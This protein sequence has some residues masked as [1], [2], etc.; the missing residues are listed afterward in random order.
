[1]ELIVSQYSI[2]S[3]LFAMIFLISFQSSPKKSVK[4][5]VTIIDLICIAAC[6]FF[7]YFS[8][9][10]MWA[11]A[12]FLNI[13]SETKK[14]NSF[15]AQISR[16]C[17]FLWI[18]FNMTHRKLSSY[19]SHV[20]CLHVTAIKIIALLWNLREYYL[21]ESVDKCLFFFH[22]TPQKFNEKNGWALL[23]AFS[24]AFSK[25]FPKA[26]HKAF[27]K[28]FL[29]VC[30]KIFLVELPEAFPETYP[31]VFLEWF[32]EAFPK[33]FLETF[34]HFLFLHSTFMLLKITI[35]A[36][37]EF[38]LTSTKSINQCRLC[39]S[40]SAILRNL[41]R[42]LRVILNLKCQYLPQSP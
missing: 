2:F 10:S 21:R 32:S 13:F 25:A 23:E 30:L 42:F 6:L 35:V 24:M 16:I 11:I 27:P 38:F 41:L 36:D 5:G 17:Y 12:M 37:H 1:M 29:K 4:S 20:S 33:P 9:Q 34:F 19:A 15:K 18:W 14:Q 39:E 8:V 28:P 3:F 31:K 7:L 22:H 26:F 40:S